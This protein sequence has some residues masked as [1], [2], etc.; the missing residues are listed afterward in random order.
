MLGHFA[1]SGLTWWK[2]VTSPHLADFSVCGLCASLTIIFVLCGGIILNLV[3]INQSY[4]FLRHIKGYTWVNS[5]PS[6]RPKLAANE[7]GNF[8]YTYDYRTLEFGYGNFSSVFLGV[9]DVTFL[10]GS[11][12]AIVQ[13]RLAAATGLEN[14]DHKIT[15]YKKR[16]VCTGSLKGVEKT[17]G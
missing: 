11:W 9:I 10:D 7:D 3:W 2:F 4:V 15:L 14:G 5:F 1:L 16:G 6:S 13:L 8:R 17:E 12:N